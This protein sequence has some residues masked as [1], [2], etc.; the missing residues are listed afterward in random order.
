MVLVDPSVCE[1]ALDPETALDL[2]PDPETG[3]PETGWRYP[4]R[5]PFPCLDRV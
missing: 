3:D 5:Y 4:L 1:T 2:R